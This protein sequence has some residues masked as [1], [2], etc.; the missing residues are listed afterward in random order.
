MNI[1][2]K[3]L[4]DIDK[5]N[6][7]IE[8]SFNCISIFDKDYFTLKELCSTFI[9]NKDKEDLYG[10]NLIDKSI[11]D[12]INC[13]LYFSSGN[14]N[15]KKYLQETRLNKGIFLNNIS[16]REMLQIFDLEFTKLVIRIKTEP[17]NYD[18]TKQ[19]DYLT[20]NACNQ[21]FKTHNAYI[22]HLG[23]LKHKNNIY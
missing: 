20:C 13:Y 4:K 10:K 22:R 15:Y 18:I 3:K 23:T 17:K 14:S 8:E 1:F 12:I 9:L 21:Q 5:L 7:K 11:L 16:F 19:P 6:D 2:K